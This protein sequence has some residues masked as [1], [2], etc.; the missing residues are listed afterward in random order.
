MA[1]ASAF[2]ANAVAD[3][4]LP[5]PRAAKARGIGPCRHVS[6][7]RYIFG[8]DWARKQPGGRTVRVFGT[9]QKALGKHHWEVAWCDGTTTEAVSRQ[10]RQE[11]ALPDGVTN[12]TNGEPN[13]LSEDEYELD[14][15]DS[16]DEDETPGSPK[17]GPTLS[18]AGP[19]VT[20]AS[21]SNTVTTSSTTS[22][23]SDESGSSSG[24]SSDEND[25]SSDDE[26]APSYTPPTPRKCPYSRLP[27]VLSSS[28]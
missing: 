23:S 28:A 12:D 4:A 2:G 17:A 6:A 11:T 19:L 24:S 13:A 22:S 14:M 18:S 25:S 10:L 15:S 1:A 9:V 8:E 27:T 20:T 5:M 21:T 7:P 3:A 26:P 16:D